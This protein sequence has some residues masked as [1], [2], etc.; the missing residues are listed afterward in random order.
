MV[1]KSEKL[2]I[3]F[4]KTSDAMKMDKINKDNKLPGKIIPVP[5]EISAGCGMAYSIDISFEEKINELINQNNINYES[6]HHI[7]MC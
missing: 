1:S 2:V 3:A 4:H 6:M 5:R 7:S